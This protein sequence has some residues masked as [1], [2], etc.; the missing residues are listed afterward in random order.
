MFVEPRDVE[1]DECLYEVVPVL[2]YHRR[3]N[4][5]FEHMYRFVE[6]LVIAQVEMRAHQVVQSF[7]VMRRFY[8]NHL[9]FCIEQV[10]PFLAIAVIQ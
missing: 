6:F 10:D 8:F 1:V 7:D 4:K 9:R 5:M 2:L 3:F